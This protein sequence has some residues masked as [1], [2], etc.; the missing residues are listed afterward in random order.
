MKARKILFYVFLALSIAVNVLIIVESSVTGSGS[1]S[2]SVSLSEWFIKFLESIGITITDH[3]AFHS[4]FRKLVGHFLLF[5]LSGIF[6][7]LSL[8]MNDYLMN[9]F[10]WKTT[11]FCL[12]LGVTIAVISEL[13]QALVPERYGT[14]TD[15]FIDLAGFVGFAGIVYLIYFLIIRHKSKKKLEVENAK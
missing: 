6:T 15:V 11:L 10:K 4:M 13:I 7:M 1:A 2:Q 8:V 14:F 12:G 9:K 5:G 3:A